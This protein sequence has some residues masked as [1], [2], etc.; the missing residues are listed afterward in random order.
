MKVG[1]AMIRNTLDPIEEQITLLKNYGCEHVY[2]DLIFEKDDRRIGLSE[3]LENL[4]SN[5]TLAIQSMSVVTPNM[6][7]PIGLAEILV[8]KNCNLYLANTDE[9]IE[10]VELEYFINNWADMLKFREMAKSRR[11]IKGIK[12]FQ[13]KTFDN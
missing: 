13:N 3:L 11:T 4:E 5:A 6:D 9:T 10:S 2:K 12:N 1:Y 8:E 7:S